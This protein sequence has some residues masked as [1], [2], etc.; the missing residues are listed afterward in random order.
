MADLILNFETMK[1]LFT[2]TL[3]MLSIILYAQNDP[4]REKLDHVFT[5]I[6]KSQVPTGFL[7]EYGN[8]FLP[9]DVFNGVLT[10]SNKLTMDIWRQVYATLYSS[11]IYG[12]N[13]LP[14]LIDVNTSVDLAEAWYYD[15]DKHSES[16]NVIPVLML[17]VP[18]NYLRPDAITSKLLRVQDDQLYDVAGRVKS[19][20]SNRTCFAA[21]PSILAAP[22]RTASF[23]FKPE[24]FYNTSGKIVSDL[25]ID[26]NDGEPHYNKVEWNN[27]ITHVYSVAGTKTIRIKLQFTDYTSVECFALLEVVNPEISQGIYNLS[28]DELISIKANANH[29]G[30]KIYIEYDENDTERTLNKPLII[31]EG[32][33]V[34]KIAPKV[35][36]NYSYDDFVDDLN[37][38][39]YEYDI[40]YQLDNIAGYDLILLDYNYG[41][42]NIT[43]NAELVREV[44]QWVNDHKTGNEQ[45]VVM[46]ISMGGLVARYALASMTKQN[47][48]TETRLLITHDSPHRGANTPLGIQFLI[49]QLNDINIM[50][51][52]YIFDLFPE[53]KQA[54]KVLNE[55]A[56]KELLIARATNGSGGVSY[57]SFLDGQYRNIITFKSTDPQPSYKTIA[58]SLGSECAQPNLVPNTTLLHTKGKFFVSPIPWIVR[59]SYNT[60]IIVNA[61]PDYGESKRLSKVRIW[62]N[63]KILS[64]ISISINLTNKS[65][66][67]PSNLLSWD[68]APGGGQS[69]Q[70]VAGKLPSLNIK[71]LAFF[72]LTLKTTYFNGKFCFV[73]TVSA[74]DVTTINQEALTKNYTGGLSPTNP[75]RVDNFIAQKKISSIEYNETHPDFTAENAEWLFDEMQ[76]IDN[77]LNCSQE[78]GVEYDLSISGSSQICTSGTYRLNNAP[79][80]ASVTWEVTPAHLFTVSSGIGTTAV[81]TRVSTVNRYCTVIYTISSPCGPFTFSRTITVGVPAPDI[82]VEMFESQRTARLTAT[83]FPESTYHWYVDYDSPKDGDNIFESSIP[84][85]NNKKAIKCSYTNACGTSKFSRIVHLGDCSLAESFSISPNPSS[86]ELTVFLEDSVQEILPKSIELIL[87]NSRQEKVYAT[88]ATDSKTTIPVRDLPNGDYYLHVVGREGIILQ[89]RII[90]NH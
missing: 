70:S 8:P 52:L 30:G 56:T 71:W 47:L 37:K 7:E 28:H 83:L 19:P 74:L 86:D 79:S 78:C 4:L 42:D 61:L 75:V 38:I 5:N 69:V 48:D 43:R 53:L 45:N 15:H 58:T 31:I 65:A 62:I 49:R 40:N 72:N 23:V 51:L 55:P 57:N 73:P 2:L 44:I 24:L 9:L 76:E 68:G 25:Y 77:N 3:S 26:F 50:K 16:D 89:R 14:S 54:N 41:T 22:N 27:T 36:K 80:D 66:N 1:K 11:R 84:R 13:P 33:D 20:Y 59:R 46:G 39:K 12:T 88:K 32:Y 21:T 29:S 18:Y 67:S 82:N 34:S 6:N 87:F 63:Y 64:F 17:Y 81:L 35:Q 85:C 60:E 90:V 10:D